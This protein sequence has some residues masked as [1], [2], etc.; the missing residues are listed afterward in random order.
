[1]M[2]LRKPAV[3]TD[4]PGLTEACIHGGTGL[5]VE[6]RNSVALANSIISLLRDPARAQAMGQAARQRVET[7]F[8]FDHYMNNIMSLYERLTA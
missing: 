3:V 7:N 6:R 5:V 2:A 8:T 4:L 1:F